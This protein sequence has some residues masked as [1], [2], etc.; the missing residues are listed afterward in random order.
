MDT[1]KVIMEL[2]ASA[3]K[4]RKFANEIERDGLNLLRIPTL[5]ICGYS[6]EEIKKFIDFGKEREFNPKEER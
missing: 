6:M 3:N 1:E 4:M 5:T 2:R